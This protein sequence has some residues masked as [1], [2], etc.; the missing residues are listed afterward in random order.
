MSALEHALR[1]SLAA[2]A[3][4]PFPLE[5]V[6]PVE[7]SPIL[8]DEARS[9]LAAVRVA[10][11]RLAGELR[12]GLL[13]AAPRDIWVRYYTP[14]NARRQPVRQWLYRGDATPALVELV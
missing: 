8:L 9:A 5:G 6:W 11:P 10:H 12:A 7:R 13:G 3:R 2:I 4:E 14:G 1:A